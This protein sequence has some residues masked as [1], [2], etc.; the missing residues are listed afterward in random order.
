MKLVWALIPLILIGIGSLN[1]FENS[2][3]GFIC[4]HSLTDTEFDVIDNRIFEI[5]KDTINISG[6]VSYNDDNYLHHDLGIFSSKIEDRISTMCGNYNNIG[7]DGEHFEIIF[8]HS[9]TSTPLGEPV[10]FE[11]QLKPLVP[12]YYHLFPVTNVTGWIPNFGNYEIHRGAN[13]FPGQLTIIRVK[14]FPRLQQQLESNVS[15][16]DLNCEQNH[17]LVFRYDHSPACVKP[18]TAEKLMERGWTT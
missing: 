6:K 11:M 2:V 4:P 1:M 5:G 10:I 8:Q 13:D 12:G 9:S 14:E 7:N 17:L 16:E 3:E 15:L 18:A